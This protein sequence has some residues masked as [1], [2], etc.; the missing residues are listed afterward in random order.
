MFSFI[1][2][3][4]RQATIFSSLNKPFKLEFLTACCVCVL[5]DWY[6]IV[7]SPRIFIPGTNLDD[8]AYHSKIG[9]QTKPIAYIRRNKRFS[10]KHFAL[11]LRIGNIEALATGGVHSKLRDN[12]SSLRVVAPFLEILIKN[13]PEEFMMQAANT[14][15]TSEI[16]VRVQKKTVKTNRIMN[17][18]IIIIKN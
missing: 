2:Y 10:W 3:L 7:T 6:F 18:Y 5:Q 13:L 14:P 11:S 9:Y 15:Y 4:L 1:L 17:Q 16:Y 8:C 12:E